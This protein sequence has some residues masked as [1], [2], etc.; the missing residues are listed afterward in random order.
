MRFPSNLV[1]N[2]TPL[3]QD[4]KRKYCC[5]WEHAAAVDLRMRQGVLG[6]W[7]FFSQLRKEKKQEKQEKENVY[8]WFEALHKR[9]EF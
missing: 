4:L 1:V 7:F 3:K 8:V 5:E 2:F 9:F 6:S